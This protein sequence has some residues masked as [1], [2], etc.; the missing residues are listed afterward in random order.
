[1]WI[2]QLAL[3]RPYTFVVAAILLL[4]LTPFILMRMATD[5]FP[6]I[7][8]PDTCILEINAL[9]SQ[10]ITSHN[11]PQ[12]IHSRCQAVTDIYRP[13]GFHDNRFSCGSS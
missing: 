5:I 11:K 4:L 13:F 10:H 8:I 9:T 1:M 12:A 7:D 6:V 2:V 3:R